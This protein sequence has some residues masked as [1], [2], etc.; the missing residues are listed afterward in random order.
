MG[1]SPPVPGG[2]EG[3]EAVAADWLVWARTEGHDDY[4]LF[5]DAFFSLVPPPR[6][7]TLEVGCGEGRVS[8][9]LAA[10]GHAITAVDASP[11]LLAAAAAA[12]PEGEYRV[13]AAERLPFPDGAF[14]LVV[15]H[16]VLMDVDDMPAAVAEAARVLAP[17]GRLCVA[18][19]HPL[20][21]AGRW[22]GPAAG[23][24]FVIDG[25]YLAAA[26]ST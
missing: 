11:T 4:W 25:S 23:A 12:H 20:A 13:A 9:D 17:G 15:A 6:G 18:V 3:F 7:R 22:A 8:R 19:T 1:A 16:N 21:D 24:P 26:S 5:R 14:H 2:P 10:R